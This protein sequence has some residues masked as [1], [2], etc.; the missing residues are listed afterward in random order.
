VE[1]FKRW[2][3]DRLAAR[4]QKRQLREQRAVEQEAYDARLVK[5]ASVSSVSFVCH[6]DTWNFIDGRVRQNTGYRPPSTD[7]Y[8]DQPRNMVKV[9]ISGP[10]LVTILIVMG[11]LSES[12]WSYGGDKAIATRIY[13]AATEIVDAVD[14]TRNSGTPLPPIVIDAEVAPPGEPEG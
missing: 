10:N 9:H 2:S 12:P 4:E 11:R 1:I 13:S 8:A 14:P 6:K 7:D 3:A 5:A